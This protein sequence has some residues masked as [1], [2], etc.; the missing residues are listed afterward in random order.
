MYKSSKEKII[1]HALST[2]KTLDLIANARM[3][4]AVR[5]YTQEGRAKDGY[6]FLESPPYLG[7][8]STVNLNTRILYDDAIEGG[9]IIP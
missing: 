6:H 7:Q 3:I 4:E 1:R 2:A 5:L 9:I 8:Q